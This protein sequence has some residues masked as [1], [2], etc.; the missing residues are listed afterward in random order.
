MSVLFAGSLHISE[1]QFYVVLDD[2]ELPEWGSAFA[3]Q[4]NQLCGAG[5]PA[6][7]ICQ[8][9]EADGEVPVRVVA[10][11]REP[12]LEAEWADAVEVSFRVP[13]EPPWL[14]EWG[15]GLT[16]ELP[17]A[18]GDYRV[19]YQARAMDDAAPHAGAPRSGPGVNNYELNI[20]PA[21]VTSDRV[22]RSGT[23]IGAAMHAGHVEPEPPA[24]SSSLG[25]VMSG[26]EVVRDACASGFIPTD[27]GTVDV[28]ADIDAPR[29]KVHQDLVTLHGWFTGSAQLP[30]GHVVGKRFTLISG[31]GL[32]FE[33]TF[34][35]LE[36]RTGRLGFGWVVSAAPHFSPVTSHVLTSV[37]LEVSRGL[38][39][40][41]TV[42][43]KHEDVPLQWQDT[44]R[45][46]WTLQLQRLVKF[47]TEGFTGPGPLD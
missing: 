9:A 42:S 10:H 41:A 36:A 5:D 19:R 38:A 29:S 2:E 32:R 18:A 45:G 21:P 20:W 23:C 6:G 31:S 37:S 14:A 46:M 44:F 40:G 16:A 26:L 7:L 28:L 34:T 30:A 1:G 11:E 39:R 27:T 12:E 13:S 35:D 15:D 22:V 33:V 4:R 24:P 17:L 43:V 8:T 25:Q 3:G 47:H